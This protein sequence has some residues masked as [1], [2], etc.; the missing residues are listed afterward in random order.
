M[1]QTR[2]LADLPRP[3]A[4]PT[5]AHRIA[6]A[7]RRLG[8]P[9]LPRLS[10]LRVT[11]ERPRTLRLAAY[12]MVA[13]L[14]LSLPVLGAGPHSSGAVAAAT[15]ETSGTA[16]SELSLAFDRAAPLSRARDI[17]ALAAKP[18]TV[19]SESPAEVRVYRVQ[20]GDTLEVIAASFH[21]SPYTI[22]FNNGV[23]DARLIHKDDVFRIPP[24]NAAIYSVKTGDTVAAV[25]GLFKV[26][27]KSIM[28]TNRLYFEP[29]N[30]S[31]GKEIL[32]PVPDSEFP[33]FVLKDAPPPSQRILYSAPLSSQVGTGPHRLKWPVGG[34]ITQY[35]WYG[36]TG[37]D[38][39][40]PYGAAIA[41]SDA[42]VVS[43]AGNV[44]VGGLRVCVTH[45]WGMVTCYYHTSAVLVQVGQRVDQGQVIARIGL[46]G[47]TTGP[48][49]H[50][51][52][53]YRGQF[54]NALAW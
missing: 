34:I 17:L 38:I 31:A 37:V 5:L 25:A 30:F 18:A 43:A 40:A 3:Q 49:V 16:V 1:K 36:H 15:T 44:A 13:G 45:D 19:T 52:A 20:D 21:V 9:G 39:A 35:F 53:K 48:H 12:G 28:D 47:V 14:M 23:T 6:R 33:N 50:W 4:R 29:D 11:V 46:T 41:A 2:G 42:G 26:D 7:R 27:A 54:V 51:E 32:V 10:D 24:L 22:A 8:F